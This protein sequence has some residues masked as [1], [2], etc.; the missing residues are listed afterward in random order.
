M[1]MSSANSPEESSELREIEY[2]SPSAEVSMAD[3]WFE[4]ATLDHFW[5]RRRFEVLQRLCGKLIYGAAEMAEIGCGHGLL[6]RQ[7]EIAYG[8]GVIGF[9]LNEYALKRNLSRQSRVCCY[10]IF[11]KDTT[12]RERFDVIFLFDVLEHISDEDAFLRTLLFHL[13][14]QGNLII[15]VPAGQWAYSEYDVAAGH[16]RRY[17]INTLRQTTLR[18]RLDIQ[19]WTYWGLPLVPSLMIRKL[20]LMG[21]HDRSKVITT[22]FDSRSTSINSALATLSSLEWIPQKLLGTS[23][24]AV[25]KPVLRES[26]SNAA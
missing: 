23:L 20:W 1:A 25:F 16:V 2:L 24:M 18:N 5:I 17:M 3:R 19:A 21:K 13:A 26:N 7:I 11:Q 15:N 8:R 10:D 6:Q 12:L 9:D 22:G 4:I 14:P